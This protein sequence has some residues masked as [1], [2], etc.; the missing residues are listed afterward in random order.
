MKKIGLK[1]WVVVILFVLCI[2][3]A[4]IEG[5]EIFRL[6]SAPCCCE[7]NSLI[8]FQDSLELFSEPEYRNVGEVR[9]P[10]IATNAAKQLWTEKGYDG[11]DE[12]SIMATYCSKYH[13]WFIRE[14]SGI[15]DTTLGVSAM[16]LIRPDGE[17][18]AV[19]MG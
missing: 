2:G 10:E 7:R 19:W 12:S 11:I 3:V 17:V 8:N 13:F 4:V 9:T 16:A 6:R 1:S 18:L 15:F 5:I 14:T